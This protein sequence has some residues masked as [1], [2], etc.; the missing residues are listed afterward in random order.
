MYRRAAAGFISYKRTL[1]FHAPP[2]GAVIPRQ[3][4]TG[5]RP[6]PEFRLFFRVSAVLSR[7]RHPRFRDR[8]AATNVAGNC[9]ARGNF[10]ATTGRQ[11][12]RFAVHRRNCSE[13]GNATPRVPLLH[14]RPFRARRMRYR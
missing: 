12:Q 14:E 9:F 7:A 6:A 1:L 3:I 11:R 10:V 13:N 5:F 8:K 4:I 2:D